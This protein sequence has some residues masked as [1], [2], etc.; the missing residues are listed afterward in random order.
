MVHPSV[1]VRS[2]LLGKPAVLEAARKRRRAVAEDAGPERRA[3]PPRAAV[4]AV[5]EVETDRRPKTG[6]GNQALKNPRGG[7]PQAL[8]IKWVRW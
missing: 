5:L 2:R 1:N 4:V 7:S 6:A 3:F 8:P